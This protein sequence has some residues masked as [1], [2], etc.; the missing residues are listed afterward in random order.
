MPAVKRGTLPQHRDREWTPAIDARQAVAPVDV[1]LLAEIT[2]FAVPTV[3][4]T[5]GRAAGLY[6]SLEDR[7]DRST[8]HQHARQ[9][10]TV[11][12]ALRVYTRKEKRLACIDISDAHHRSEEHTSELQSREKLVCRR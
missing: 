5:Q 3:K 8:K 6:R 12:A 7:P 9:G 1:Q 11:S 2:R 10:D 4:V